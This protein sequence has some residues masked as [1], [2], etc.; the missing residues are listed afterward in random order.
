L[1]ALALAI[2]LAIAGTTLYIALGG[3][4]D[5]AARRRATS[6][7]TSTGS[8][9]SDSTAQ[10]RS[11]VVAVPPDTASPDTGLI[12]EEEDP[13]SIDAPL[14]PKR[15]S[16]PS[17]ARKQATPVKAPASA[18][19]AL[20]TSTDVIRPPAE[21]AATP[22]VA[23]TSPDKSTADPVLE[24]PFK[25]PESKSAARASS[26]EKASVPIS[27]CRIASHTDQTACLAAYIAQGDGEMVGAFESLVTELRRAA[28]TAA[29]APDP[30]T[31]GRI[32]VEQRAWLSVR[33]AE[34]PRDPAPG[35]GTFW[36][37]ATSTCFTEMA[38]ARAAELR[39][40]VIRLRRSRDSALRP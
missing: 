19:G 29:G 14:Y 7:T 11:V 4:A 15:P 17:E 9:V 5:S 6:V 33:S 3:S 31:V 22:N 23:A 16:P 2:P 37:Q 38:T 8:L 32:R 35:A 30:A 40:A 39:D 12:I 27:R 36:A 18:P 25:F 26:G 28:G 10:P 24:D 1:R 21:S 20:A 13:D 34:C